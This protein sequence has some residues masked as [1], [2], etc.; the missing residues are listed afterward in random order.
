MPI[1]RKTEIAPTNG[2]PVKRMFWSIIS[3]YDLRTA[4]CELVDNALD[5]WMMSGRKKPLSIAIHTDL[6]RQSIEIIDDSGGV[7]QEELR[8]L[9]VPG[10]SR[11]KPADEVIGIFGVGGKRAAIALAETV[12]IRTRYKHQPTY[13]LDITSEWLET[14]GWDLPTYEI[15]NIDPGTTRIEMIKLRK[16]FTKEEVM[17]LIV[18]FGE[19][20]SWFLGQGC[21]IKVDGTSVETCC[22]DSWAYPRGFPP[23]RATFSLDF[24]RDGTQKVSI[25]G[26]L[27]L[28]RD[29]VAENYG[30]Y[31]YCNHR[32]IVRALKTRDV[33]YFITGE[34]GVPHPDAS[35]CRVIVDIQGGARTMPW[36]SNKSGIN[37]KHPSFLTIRPT[38]I[39]MVSYFSSLSRRLK[40]TWERD[41]FSH[42]TGEIEDIDGDEVAEAKRLHLP[43]LP[44][45]NKPEVEKLKTR[46]RKVLS[47]QP[48]AVGLLEA[49]AAVS[50]LERQRFETRNRMAL[51][52]LDSN[53][54]IALKEFIVH[55][56]DLF[57]PREFDDAKIRTLFARRN[58]VVKVIQS[59][60]SIPKVTWDKAAHYY[61]LRNKLI[62]ERATLDISPSD[63]AS[64]R[65]TV[66]QVLKLLF[67]MRF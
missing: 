40:H 18:H 53:F 23:R 39:Q 57:S 30:V 4:M 35:L 12:M 59:K 36:T 24:G 43:A 58:E 44:K 64:Y 5:L 14:E 63:V 3:D 41:V 49:V 60:V 27:I 26:G 56:K 19:T 54:E 7:K 47:E 28:D 67:G 11:N 37:D 65:A 20:Y 22:F 16:P 33:G 15:P 51:I 61:E 8:L 17:G 13:E 29:A 42:P 62:H 32:L 21:G 34:A 31:V 38:L 10:G 55:R 1:E 45:V 46:N 50:V 48:W 6:E 2:T 9:I 25:M 52:L 66:E